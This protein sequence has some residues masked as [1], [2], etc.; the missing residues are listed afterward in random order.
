MMMDDD[1]LNTV[2]SSFLM[3]LY[4]FCLFIIFVLLIF[5][6]GLCI[7]VDVCLMLDDG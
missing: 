7:L 2:V 5:D 3:M 6:V 1:G 4:V